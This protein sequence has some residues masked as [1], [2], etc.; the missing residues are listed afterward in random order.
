MVDAL[1]ARILGELHV[2]GNNKS[3]HC[4]YPP[5]YHLLFLHL[6]VYQHV[7]I[8]S[9]HYDMGVRVRRH[10]KPKP[11]AV[12]LQSNKLTRIHF[13]HMLYPHH[14][15]CLDLFQG[16]NFGKD[17]LAI[18]LPYH[19]GLVVQEQTRVDLLTAGEP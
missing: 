13:D 17:M 11:H 15:H 1:Q 19:L 4:R 10:H 18:S 5:Y 2:E 9:K 7:Y 3:H 16:R 8:K 14:F 12:H 6:Q